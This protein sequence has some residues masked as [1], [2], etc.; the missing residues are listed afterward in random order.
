[1]SAIAASGTVSMKTNE[2]ARLMK[3]RDRVVSSRSAMP[4]RM[5]ASTASR[6]T[7]AVKPNVRHHLPRTSRE[8]I[9]SASRPGRSP[10]THA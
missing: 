9:A 6:S 4:K 5:L 2:L 1:V 8:L 10:S 7:S 3:L